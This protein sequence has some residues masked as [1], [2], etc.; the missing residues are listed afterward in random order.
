[1]SYFVVMVT[2]DVT[3]RGVGY[4]AC[5]S[6]WERGWYVLGGYVGV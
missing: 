2:P 3:F 1:M 5:V 4:A 6:W